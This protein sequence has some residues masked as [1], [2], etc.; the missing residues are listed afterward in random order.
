MASAALPP[1][2]LPQMQPVGLDDL[3]ERHREA[4]LWRHALTL[5]Y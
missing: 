3:P 2:D 4:L 5:D 1:D